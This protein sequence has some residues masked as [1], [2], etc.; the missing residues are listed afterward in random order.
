MTDEDDES[1]CPLCRYPRPKYNRDPEFDCVY[2]GDVN[3]EH[4]ELQLVRSQLDAAKALIR[5]SAVSLA[6][7]LRS[8]AWHIIE[9]KLDELEEATEAYS[10]ATR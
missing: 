7:V 8:T 2:E 6:I 5:V 9:H 10:K 3:C 4:R 1:P